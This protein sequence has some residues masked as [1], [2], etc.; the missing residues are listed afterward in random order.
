MNWKTY[1]RMGR[2]QKE[3]YDYRFRH[4]EL[5][6]DIGKMLPWI[7]MFFM[8]IN[9]LMF[10]AYLFLVGEHFTKYESQVESILMSAMNVVKIM[11]P[12]IV[13][14]LAYRIVVIFF[15]IWSEYKWR[16]DNNI[17]TVRSNI[18]SRWGKK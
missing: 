11:L 16:K 8:S 1:D 9:M 7:V 10:I 2:S 14:T 18:F 6:L 5:G 17:Q 13:I 12:L 15:Y 3:E 4:R